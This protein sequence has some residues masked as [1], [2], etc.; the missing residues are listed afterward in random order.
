MNKNKNLKS[1]RK[2]KIFKTAFGSALNSS[3]F[4]LFLSLIVS[5]IPMVR[6]EFELPSINRTP[7]F[8]FS[9]SHHRFDIYT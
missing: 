1:T 8:W 7:L 5:E 3:T 6:V 4:P 2:I 9:F